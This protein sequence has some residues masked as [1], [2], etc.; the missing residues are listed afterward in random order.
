MKN[1]F[2]HR[3]LRGSKYPKC[4]QAKK[5]IFLK[6]LLDDPLDDVLT[7]FETVKDDDRVYEWDFALSNWTFYDGESNQM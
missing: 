3:I 4:E 7:V 2:H 5:L 1:G 6:T